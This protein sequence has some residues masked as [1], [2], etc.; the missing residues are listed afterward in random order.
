MDNQKLRVK[1]ENLDST[2]KDKETTE[3]LDTDNLNL[4]QILGQHSFIGDYQGDIS[5][6]IEVVDQIRFTQE[7]EDH[8]DL[9]KSENGKIDLKSFHEAKS[10][11]S[12]AME[13]LKCEICYD[14][15][16]EL[17]TSEP[18]SCKHLFCYDCYRGYLNDK[19]LSNKVVSFF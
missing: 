19:L 2:S 7:N 3:K 16:T 15:L 10:N 17:N 18:L 12:P 9:A 8:K 5:K 6:N 4:T 14:T 11:A 13:T 1:I